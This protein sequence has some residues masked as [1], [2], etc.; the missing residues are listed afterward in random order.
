MDRGV[1]TRPGSKVSCNGDLQAKKEK[2]LRL[3][4]LS[5]SP[6]DKVM[7]FKITRKRLCK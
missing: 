3:S 2:M 6:L 1:R 7:P 4:K 5:R